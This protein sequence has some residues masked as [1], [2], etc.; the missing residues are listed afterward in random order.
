MQ[1]NLIFSILIVI[2]MAFWGS[3]WACGKVLVQ[4]A[5]ADII[6]FWRFFFAFIASIPLIMLLKVPL[7]INTENLKFLLVAA[8]LNGIYSIFFFMGLNYGS[9]GK[10]GVLVTTLIPIFAYLLAYF[11]SRKENKSIKANEILGLGI[12]IIS[13]ICLL[14]LGGFEELFGKFNTFFLFCALDWAI[15]TLV[16]QRIRIH[17]LAIN[18]YITFLSMLFYSPL[19]FFKPQMLEIFHYDMKF[20]SMI[21]VVAVLSTAIGTSIYYM[22]IAKLG[23]TRASSYQL[24]VPAMALGSSYLILGE[25]PSLLTIF[26]GILAI[27]ATYL[28][29]IHKPKKIGQV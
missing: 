26:G 7:R 15:L 9:A 29:N 22:G 27:F 21:F 1:K 4:Y 3:S 17:P 23:A 18:F 6:A 10:G 13:G 2:A 12:G 19:F 20:W 14:D 8:C 16:C 25:I 24:L 5:S 28:I 11:F